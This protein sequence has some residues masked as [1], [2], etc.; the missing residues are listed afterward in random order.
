MSAA[1]AASGADL[2]LEAAR[3]KAQQAVKG[4]TA[5]LETA[6][7][8]R[9]TAV[10]RPGQATSRPAADAKIEAARAGL[11]AALAEGEAMIHSAVEAKKLAEFDVQVATSRLERAGTELVKALNKV[12]VQLPV[13][14]IVFLPRLPVRVQEIQAS[15]GNAASGPVFSVTDNQLMI[16]SALPLQAAPLVKPGMEVHIDE[17]AYGVKTKGVVHHV[18]QT[19][20]THGVDGYHIYLAV[21]V[22]DTPVRLDGFSLRLTIPVV[23]TKGMVLAV[24]ISAV[25]LGADGASR[26]AFEE[27][28][29]LNSVIVEPGMAADGYVE[30]SSSDGILKPGR[31]VVVG[32]ESLSQAS[33]AVELQEPKFALSGLLDGAKNAY[34]TAFDLLIE[35]INAGNP[36]PQERVT[37]Q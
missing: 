25:S 23:S 14:E 37:T 22:H 26:V 18:E 15:V 33:K 9:A 1:S 13:D 32:H 27:E 17:P 6:V 16:G 10:V 5:D 19:P 29:R 30:I 4:A 7:S 35:A 21:R 31:L 3:L 8:E 11:R 20:G 28:G 36:S 34:E 12:G 24:P 2:A